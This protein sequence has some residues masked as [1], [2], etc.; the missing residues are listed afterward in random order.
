MT[1]DAH[2]NVTST[3]TCAAVNN[4]Q[5]SYASYYEN[6]SNPL[7]P[8]NDKPTDSRDARSSSPTDP[9]YDTVTTYTTAGQIAT[10]ATPPTLACPSGCTTTYSYTTGTEAAVGGGTEPGGLLASVTPRAAG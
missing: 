5:T 2:N 10:E 1:Y 3:T 7:D 9:A 6:L 4:C 8:R